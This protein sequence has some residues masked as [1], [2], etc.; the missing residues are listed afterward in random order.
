[1]VP[2]FWARTSVAGFGGA[3]PDAGMAAEDEVLVRWFCSLMGKQAPAEG[4]ARL[5]RLW[6]SRS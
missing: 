5:V 1:M 4:K 3:P 2:R 6:P